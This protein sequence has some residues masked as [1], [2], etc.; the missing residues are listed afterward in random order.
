[1][2]TL[3]TKLRLHWGIA[4]ITSIWA[5]LCIIL[6]CTWFRYQ[7]NPDA[8]SYFT[9]AYKYA[10]GDLRHALNGY[11][12]PLY[13]A[14]LVPAV[15]LHANMIIAAK[16]LGIL[17]GSALLLTTYWFLL[18][19]RV[20]T[21]LANFICIPLAIYLVGWITYGPITPD[22]LIALLIVWLV[23]L[24]GR[25]M[26]APTPKR[27][28]T[29]G[30]LGAAMY[31]TKGF[32]LFLFIGV[33]GVV[34]MWQWWQN[35]VHLMVIIRRFAPIV[36]VFLALTLPFIGLYSVK[37]HKLTINN[38]GAFDHRVYGP[39]AKQVVPML[40][41]GPLAPPNNSAISVWEEPSRVTALIPTWSP[42]DSHAHL[43][44]FV[45]DIVFAN[46]NK[47]LHSLDEF[48]PLFGFG[49][50]CI[51]LIL[52]Q[53][54]GYRQEAS[55]FA[56]TTLLM[57]A[58]YCLVLT[59]TRYLWAVVVYALLGA[60]LWLSDLQ[61]RGILQ[62]RQIAIVGAL[63]CS[64][65]GTYVAQQVYNQRR[66]GKLGHDYAYSLQ[67]VLPKGSHIIADS[68]DDS[69]PT[70]WYLKAQCF[71]VLAPPSDP[72]GQTKY[73]ELLKQLGVTYYVDYHVGP[74]S[75]A[76]T[77]FVANYYLQTDNHTVDGQQITTYR[78]IQ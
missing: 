41:T 22:L 17:T 4:A 48:G 6:I 77:D 50:A 19:R 31:F 55:L 59:E 78:L 49:L 60:G 67:N 15:W 2:N 11:W 35:R 18:Q 46:L 57:I 45:H 38:A 68:F 32:G 47:T 30:L 26:S 62:V 54:K 56:L 66:T 44:Y 40:I 53:Q 9:I 69:Y 58:G 65:A 20:S 7:I 64:I 21:L 34:A 73:Y 76:L 13:S 43:H 23:I 16:F 70:C 37:Y 14:L 28:V 61:K 8:T 27:G 1:M 29:L 71:S 42:L 63:I 25:F 10:H 3:L 33:I 12:G 72:S 74:R 39:V 24:V 51:M 36:I 75:Q 52:L 5:L